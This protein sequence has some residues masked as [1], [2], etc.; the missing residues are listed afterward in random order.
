MEPDGA[1]GF[2]V[3]GRRSALGDRR[4]RDV[5]R[6]TDTP[7][8][9]GSVAVAAQFRFFVIVMK[10]KVFSGYLEAGGEAEWMFVAGPRAG[11]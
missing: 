5:G 10:P 4:G 2:V 7:A 9:R 6:R 8:S 1:T 3:G 11:L